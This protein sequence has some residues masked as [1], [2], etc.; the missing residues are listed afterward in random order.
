MSD[1]VSI[2]SLE[3]GLIL[4]HDYCKN[5]QTVAV[6]LLVRFG[7]RYEREKFGMA[8]FIEHMMFK[9][10][11]KRNYKQI[12]IEVEQ[13]GAD[14]NAYTSKEHTVY[15]I[16]VLKDYL[17]T[18]LEILSDLIVNSTFHQQEVDKERNVILQ[19]IAE[20]IDDP[21]EY[22][23]DQFSDLCFKNQPM[24]H[25]ILGTPESL[26]EITR[27]DLIATKERYYNAQNILISIAGEVEL[28]SIVDLLN[29]N[30]GNLSL[31]NKEDF[32]LAQFTP[33]AIMLN[34]ELE[35]SHVLIGLE[36]VSYNHPQ[37]Y[38]QQLFSMILGG[39]M[40]SRLFQ[41][42]REQRGLAYHVSSFT[43]SYP[44]IGIF[45]VNASSLSDNLETL[46][47]VMIDVIKSMR[48]I[49]EEELNRVK[50]QFKASSLMAQD[51]VSFR[52][53]YLLNSYIKYHKIIP[54]SQIVAKVTKISKSE[55]EDYYHF[56]KQSK[57]ALGIIGNN[58]KDEYYNLINLT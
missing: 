9:G 11:N 40:S 41:E 1:S 36:S 31:G 4:L 16:N 56:L 54:I 53:E 45:G 49:E 17:P 55:V 24:G 58:N 34:R 28:K 25:N 7:T 19:E 10:T 3:N 20:C 29:K 21:E 8:H 30:F 48:D 2:N 46:I 43:T 13:I 12:A 42:I 57:I 44:D 35:Q 22:L 5:M 37:F 50:Q 38:S 23:F 52:A 26:K 6:R 32:E 51:S 33:G 14:L 15:T 39:G 27:D 47:T 18:A